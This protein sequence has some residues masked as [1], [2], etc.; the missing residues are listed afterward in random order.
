MI[1]LRKLLQIGFISVI[2]TAAILFTACQQATSN[3]E[4][5]PLIVTV[6]V[7]HTSQPNQTP[8]VI[9]P[10]PIV[11]PLTEG[12][13][14]TL[15][16]WTVEPI[17]YLAEEAIDGFVE[18]NLRQFE[19]D[20]PTVSV[21]LQVK[22]TTGKGGVLDFL[23]TAGQVAPAIL[24]DVAIL[25][26]VDLNQAQTEGLVQ[27][28]DGRLDRSIVQDLL[29]AAR[30]MGTVNGS[31]VGVPLGLEMEHTVYNT[32]VFT[33]TPILWS[34][35]I[36]KNSRYLFPAKGNNG[37]VNDATLAQ[38]YSAGG[39]FQDD[40][41]K[42]KIDELVLRSVLTFYQQARDQGFIDASLLEAATT[43][44]IWPFYLEIPAGLSQVSVKQFLAERQGL[45]DSDFAAVPISSATATPISV[46]HG[47]VFVLVTKDV[48]RQAA[49][50]KLIES[51][52]ST[53]NNVSWN[54]INHSIPTRDS[55]FQ[56]IA[57]DDPYWVFLG[58]QLNT[59]RP[60]PRFT[61]YDRIGRIIQQAVEQVL[62]GEATAEEAAATA[63]DALTQ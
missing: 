34:D 14:M 36:S 3:A 63:V 44:D 42:P 2:G 22:K 38:Y 46:M 52:L 19:R 24:P 60:E 55:A 25:N 54:T 56:Q 48:N 11:E 39:V 13:P 1:L 37:V 7:T 30:R 28:L 41:G 27:S 12:Q 23:R 16:F 21:E 47:W 15:T 43:E 4:I 62:R 32:L 53:H 40:E 9:T 59:A 35:I 29:P 57:K 31:L 17:S 26:A 51:F 8:S 10:T 49:A 33:D 18:N 61:G 58:E 5:D 6:P 45:V 50:L 20:N